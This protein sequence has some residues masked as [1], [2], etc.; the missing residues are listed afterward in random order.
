ML[1]GIIF[2]MDGVIVDSH[3]IHIRAW[4]RLL[5]KLGRVA[6][7]QELEVV[8]DGKTKQEI[9]RYLLGELTDDQVR[10]Y[11]QEKDKLLNEEMQSI[12][13]INGIRRL[14]DDLSRAAIPLAVASS[15][16]AWRVHRLLDLLRLKNYFAAVVTGDEFRAGKSDHAIFRKAAEEIEVRSEE[17]LVFEDSV[18]GV[19]SAVALGMKCLGIADKMRAPGLLEAG[20]QR[21]YPNFVGAS[22]RQ[23]QKLFA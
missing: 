19:Q 7:D 12:R 16:S 2:D 8:R 22:L 1:K 10:A 5:G 6:T 18:S 4:K 20:A 21:V 17:S 15:G 3:P 14:L 11:G 13:T 23:L 9:L